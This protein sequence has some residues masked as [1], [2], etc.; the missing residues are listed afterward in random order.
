M[1]FA[2][3]GNHRLGSCPIAPRVLVGATFGLCLLMSPQ[4]AV[5]QLAGVTPLPATTISA[6]TANP[7]QL[8]TQF[9]SGGQGLVALARDYLTSD[10]STLAG[11]IGILANANQDQRLAIAKGLAEA[12]K[13]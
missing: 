9:P 10:K 1:T 4:L 2:S 8:L 5:A 12:A 3:V 11:L 13:L 7:G 6:F